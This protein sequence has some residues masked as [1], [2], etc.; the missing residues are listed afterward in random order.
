MDTMR[1]KF[2]TAFASNHLIQLFALFFALPAIAEIKFEPY[3]NL[4]S[5]GYQ[6][7]EGEQGWDKGFAQTFAPSLQ[8][9]YDGP[10]LRSAFQVN[11]QSIVYKDTQRENYSYTDFRLSNSAVFFKDALS[12]SLSANQSYRAQNE[13][14]VNYLDSI[15]TQND[16]AKVSSEQFSLNYRFDRFDWALTDLSFSMADS[17]SDRTIDSFEP[18]DMNVLIDADVKTVSGGVEFQSADRNRS[19]FLGS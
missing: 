17:K 8:L 19:F 4:S 7:K 6:V 14:G 1:N 11:H 12:V 16:L 10:W 9:S 5:V 18:D 3:L 13:A 15:T 2:S